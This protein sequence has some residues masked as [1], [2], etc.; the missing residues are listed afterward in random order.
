M[1]DLDGLEPERL[2][3]VEDPLAGAEQDRRDVERELV[4]D[5]G[6]EGLAHGRGATRDVH[7]D[8]AGRLA[9]SCVCGVEAVGD[10]VEGGPAFHLD[11]L[12]GVMG[13]HEHRR[14]VR[15]L[16]AP[17]AAPV[18]I[19]LA[20]DRP[21]HIPPHDVGA[22]R[23]HEPAGRRRV[24]VVGALVAEMPTVE[25]AP[26]FAEWILAALVGPSDEPVERDRH[27]AGGVRHRRPPEVVRFAS[28]DSTLVQAIAKSPDLLSRRHEAALAR[29]DDGLHAVAQAELGKD[30]RYVRLGGPVTEE[31]LLCNLSSPPRR[32]V[33]SCGRWL[34]AW[35]RVQLGRLAVEQGRLEESQ[36]LLAEALDLSLTSQNTRN[37]ALSA[38]QFFSQLVII[39]GEA[40]MQMMSSR[41]VPMF[42]N[43]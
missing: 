17:P 39:V 43:L 34:N 22:P 27:V 41:S 15:R 2:D 14:V 3:A 25:L 4:D 13:E 37:V 5:P 38:D 32:A 10:E 33:P 40:W 28:G 16:G 9:R 26:A 12:V 6:N 11:R 21:E 23:A 36:A 18:L 42:L 31:E 7:A 35:S 1:Q 29:E 20:A 24:G 8:L 30:P 19:P